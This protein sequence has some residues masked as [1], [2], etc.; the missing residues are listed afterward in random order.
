MIDST[1]VIKVSPDYHFSLPSYSDFFVKVVFVTPR[2][3]QL[4]EMD[5]K[6]EQR[7]AIKFCCRLRKSTVETVKLMHEADTDEEQLGDFTIFHWHKAL[8]KGRE[9]AA[10]LPHV[11]QPMGICIEEMR[12]TAS[13]VVREGCHITVRQLAQALYISKLSV[14]MIL[15]EKLKMGIAACWGPLFPTQE[16]K[17]RHIEICHEWLKRIEDES[18]V[19]RHVI[20]GEE[21]WIHNFD[22]TIKQESMHWKSTQSPVKKKVFR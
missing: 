2:K 11:G 9:T 1:S 16:Q 13:A 14:H 8:F 21:S 7:S 3:F 22:P 12:N 10:L 20:T 18:Y 15:H 5:V 6:N 17:D 4:S 19:M